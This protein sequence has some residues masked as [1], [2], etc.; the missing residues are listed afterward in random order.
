MPVAP[1]ESAPLYPTVR[2]AGLT[3]VRSSLDLLE[4][5]YPF[6][7]VRLLTVSE[8]ADLARKRRGREACHLPP[9][10]EQV[11]EELHRCG[12]LVPLFRVELERAPDART[13]DVSASLTP[14]NVHAT[15]ITELY[16]AAGDQRLGDPA[17]AG[18]NGLRGGLPS[19]ALPRLLRSSSLD[20]LADDGQAARRRGRA[21]RA[22]SPGM[23]GPD[24]LT[25]AK[26]RTARSAAAA[27][28]WS[29]RGGTLGA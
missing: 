17:A 3:T 11:L 19:P 10:N 6:S 12:V 22:E 13:I 4:L 16:G 26:L 1:A 7:Q 18:E 21:P 24:V 28:E 29:L 20:H 14:R 25:P 2:A 5:P 9:I 27:W 15:I 8:F 23:H